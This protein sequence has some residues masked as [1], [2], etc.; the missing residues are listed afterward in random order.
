M[1]PIRTVA[2]TP[3]LLYRIGRYPDPLAWPPWEAAETGRFGGRFDDPHGQDRVLYAAQQRLGAFVETLAIFRPSL[4]L[5]ARLGEPVDGAGRVPGDWCITRRLGM[6]HLLSGYRWLDL[7][8]PET[9][10]ALRAELASMFVLLGLD[11]FDVGDAVTRRRELTQAI[12]RWAYDHDYHGVAYGSRLD[13]TLDC[14]AIF[15]G[16][17]SFEPIEI[18][19]LDPDDPDLR[20]AARLLKLSL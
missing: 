1:M 10:E 13:Q 20:E 5:L 14:W 15:E 4:A 19:P 6:L 11:D 17:G 8:S 12:S 16:F 2:T 7:R 18:A 9:R 3:E